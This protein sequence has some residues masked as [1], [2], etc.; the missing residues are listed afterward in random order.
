[1]PD[2]I[3]DITL[4]YLRALFSF[5]YDFYNL[6]ATPIMTID[7]S[8]LEK[9]DWLLDILFVVDLDSFY[10]TYDIS[11]FFCFTTIGVI[12]ILVFKVINLVIPT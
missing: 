6:L 11:A 12:F 9:I 8:K 2:T 10:T 4:G 1:M 7:L 3:V 5:F